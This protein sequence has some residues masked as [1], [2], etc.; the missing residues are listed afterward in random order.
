MLNNTFKTCSYRW[1]YFRLPFLSVYVSQNMTE[2]VRICYL[3][4]ALYVNACTG[5][6]TV[7]LH[8]DVKSN[9]IISLHCQV[10]IISSFLFFYFQSAPQ[11]NTKH[12]E[13]NLGGL[14]LK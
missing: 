5:V 2:T 9:L 7:C 12:R 8:F 4:F 6:L 1:Y 13:I 10:V 11:H 14:S 3:D